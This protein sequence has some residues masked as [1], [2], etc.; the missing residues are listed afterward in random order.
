MRRPASRQATAS[1]TP[2]Y[3]RQ[4]PTVLWGLPRSQ[5][6]HNPMCRDSLLVQELR[7]F[8][9]VEIMHIAVGQRRPTKRRCIPSPEK[10]VC[11][12]VWKD[13]YKVLCFPLHTLH[14]FREVKQCQLYVQLSHRIYS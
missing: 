14:T 10:Y 3:Y 12:E 5:S 7:D 2:G 1:S 6:S 13:T 4:L 11:V 9:Q 8:L